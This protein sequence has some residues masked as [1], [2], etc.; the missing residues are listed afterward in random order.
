MTD[1]WDDDDEWDADDDELDKRLG[2]AKVSDDLPTFDDEE[3]LA[4]K[5]KEAADKLSQVELKKK[6]NALHAKK[7][8]EQERAEELEIAKRAMEL[9]AQAEAS[10]TPDEFRAFKQQQIEEADNALTNDLF[11]NVDN[12]VGPG[13]APAVTGD[14]VVMKD[15]KDH[16]KHARKCGE[17]LRAHGKMHLTTAFLQEVIQQS[18]DIIDDDAVS[19]LIKTL[20]VIKNEKVQESKRVKKGQAQKSKKTDK[21]A[22]L[23]IRKKQI[24]TFGDNDEY[25]QYDTI[26]AD[27]EDAFF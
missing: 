27:Y 8:E 2:L 6:G 12:K 25:D 4:L 5:E 20:N 1:N 3:D 18:K 26:G 10:M 15:M 23:E 11:G 13:S 14:K 21:K 17:A 19:E 24:E 7:R 22:E 9:E 16:L